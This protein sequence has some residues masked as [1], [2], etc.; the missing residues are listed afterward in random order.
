[1]AYL[2][3]NNELTPETVAAHDTE[4]AGVAE[5]F[6]TYFPRDDWDF[7]VSLIGMF[8]TAYMVLNRSK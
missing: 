7:Y 5:K 6:L 8:L 1:M 4:A 3:H 2:I